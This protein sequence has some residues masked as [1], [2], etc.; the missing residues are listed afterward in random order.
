MTVAI[1][2]CWAS[3]PGFTCPLLLR[4]KMGHPTMLWLP[5]SSENDLRGVLSC[6]FPVIPARHAPHTPF[7]TPCCPPHKAPAPP[8]FELE[9]SCLSRGARRDRGTHV[10]PSC[11]EACRRLRTWIPA[12]GRGIHRRHTGGGVDRDRRLRR[13]R[14]QLA[15]QCHALPHALGRIPER[16]LRRVPADDRMRLRR[17]RRAGDQQQWW[18][19]DRQLGRDPRR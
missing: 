4:T 11:V 6:R 8:P 13:I 2:P 5:F 7:S 18:S 17:G 15:S 12:G 1:S 3:V 14:R 10:S 16:H 19:G 9:G